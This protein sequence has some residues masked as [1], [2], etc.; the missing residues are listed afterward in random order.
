MNDECYNRFKKIDKIRC[1]F[2]I[3]KDGKY[4]FLVSGSSNT[5]YTVTIENKWIRCSCPDFKHNFNKT[6]CKHCILILYDTLKLFK[7]DHSFWNRKFFTPDELDQLKL[8]YKENKVK[9]NNATVDNTR[10]KI[11]KS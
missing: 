11:I 6:V 4:L 7:I 9:S 2:S 8:A 5:K 1:V 10:R 3:R